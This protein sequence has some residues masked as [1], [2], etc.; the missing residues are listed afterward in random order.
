VVEPGRKALLCP[1]G[2]IPA[3]SSSYLM[4]EARK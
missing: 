2:E 4:A 1:S 3:A